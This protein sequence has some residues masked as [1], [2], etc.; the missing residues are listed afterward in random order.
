MDFSHLAPQRRTGNVGDIESVF[1][2]LIG[3]AMAKF[4]IEMND[5][6]AGFKPGPQGNDHHAVRYADGSG[7][8]KEVLLWSASKEQCWAARCEARSQ[9][10]RSAVFTLTPKRARGPS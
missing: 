10:A 6:R 5:L 2:D 1:A 3:A 4:N 7:V 8:V 9:A